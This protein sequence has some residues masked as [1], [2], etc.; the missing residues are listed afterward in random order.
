M[1][2]TLKWIKCRFLRK[3]GRQMGQKEKVICHVTV[4]GV[5]A[6][7]PWASQTA[8]SWEASKAEAGWSGWGW[9][10]KYAPPTAGSSWGRVHLHLHGRQHHW[11]WGLGLR[12]AVVSRMVT[13]WHSLWLLES[14]FKALPKCQIYFHYGFQ[15]GIISLAWEPLRC[16]HCQNK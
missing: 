3:G 4:A 9:Q 1:K 5:S 16:F 7:L 11:K 6:H 10:H 13:W 8:G 2:Q 12:A 15:A 14:L